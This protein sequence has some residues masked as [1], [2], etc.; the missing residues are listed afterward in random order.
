MGDSRCSRLSDIPAT[1]GAESGTA[2]RFSLADDAPP[3]RYGNRDAGN[4]TGNPDIRVP[5]GIERENRLRAR[6]ARRN[7]NADREAG[8]G[9]ERPEDPVRR[10]NSGETREATDQGRFEVQRRPEG[11]EIHHVPGG[12]WLH[13]YEAMHPCC[14]WVPGSPC[15]CYC[16]EPVETSLVL[17]SGRGGQ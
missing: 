5:E 1:G 10:R 7:E 11:R 17:G 4:I 15:L 6:D 14:R 13:Q 9:D 3:G 2:S 16:R 8:R 12:T